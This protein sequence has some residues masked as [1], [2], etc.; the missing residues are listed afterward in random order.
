MTKLL[1][2]EHSQRI[3]ELGMALA[4]VLVMANSMSL[5]EIVNGWRY[6]KVGGR[7]A[8]GAVKSPAVRKAIG[9]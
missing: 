2:A 7:I 1:V 3:T 6:P 5:R 4:G 8:S 9:S